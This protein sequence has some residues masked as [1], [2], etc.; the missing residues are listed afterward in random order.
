MRLP[1]RQRGAAF[2][3][4]ALC[5]SLFV[6]LLFSIFEFSRIMLLDV[7][8]HAA[9]RS[10]ARYV[11]TFSASDD[12]QSLAAEMLEDEL[13]LFG[14]YDRVSTFSAEYVNTSTPSLNLT[15]AAGAPCGVCRLL[16]QDDMQLTVRA[17]AIMEND[18]VCTSGWGTE[19]GGG[20]E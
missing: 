19:S 6:L 15:L 16:G 8:L 9:L 14:T 13:E 11:S 2:L 12:C 18:N 5:I 1:E 17:S 7:Q 3:E 10:T 4:F 20:E